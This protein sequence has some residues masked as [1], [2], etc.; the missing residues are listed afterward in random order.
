MAFYGDDIVEQ[1]REATDIVELIQ[2]FLPLKR[3]GRNYWARCP[4]H[5]EK[6]PSFS[7]S[8]DKQIYHCFGCQKGGNVFSFV[9]E[10]EKLPFPEALKYLAKRANIQL[11]EVGYRRESKEFERLYYAHEVAVDFFA[12][13]LRDSRSTLQYL[14]ERKLTDETIT[15]FRLGYAPDSW[16]AFIYHAHSKDLSDDDLVK[17]GLVVQKDDGGIYDRF[18][19]RLT[20]TIFNTVQKPIAFGAR[21]L[22][23]DE[24]AKY[25]NSPE[26]SLYSKARVLYGL[27][28]SRTEIR[29]A[30]E[31]IVVEGYFDYLS[32]YQVGVK[33]VVASSGTAFTQEQAQLLGRSAASVILMFDSDSAGQQAA[34]RS[35]DHLFAAGLDV[36]VVLLPSGEDPDS[37]A[38]KGGVEAVQEQLLKAKSFVEFS[39]GTLPDR[40]E[41]LSLSMKHKAI[42]RLSEL[43]NMIGEPIKRQLF[44][45]EIAEWY[46]ITEA[47]F[48]NIMG[49]DQLSSRSGP[50]KREPIHS[51]TSDDFL[52]LIFQRPNLFEVAQRFI[53]PSD[54]T[55]TGARDIFILMAT[56][57]EEGLGIGPAALI[58]RSS[59]PSTKERIARLGSAIVKR[60]DVDHIF[61]KDLSRLLRS[62]LEKRK[63]ELKETLMAAERA[64]DQELA[65]SIQGEI[66][67]INSRV[68]DLRKNSQVV[69]ED[70]E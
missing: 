66:V 5:Q 9:M 36:K 40:Y 15:R 61:A 2:E 57:R 28:H 25:I 33:N 56:L 53:A 32:L 12:E 58:D 46:H 35:V 52:S 45:Q 19:N 26:T 13:H 62:V 63:R 64:G 43:A 41:N 4:F 29:K 21:A 11:P 49:T 65:Q 7:V 34:I 30:E 14:R 68:N 47:E 8:P 60:G 31:A 17:S 54:L 16:E 6:T 51:S 27:S 22:S 1:V 50:A 37:L 23:K 59:D 69:L 18:R 3:K 38:R 20:F 39:L 24:S 70:G 44:I 67:S 48:K 42:K 55:E 10:H